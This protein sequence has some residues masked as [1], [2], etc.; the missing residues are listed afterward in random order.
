MVKTQQPRPT[1]PSTPPPPYREWI[2]ALIAA[3]VGAPFVFVFAQAMA[4]AELRRFENPMRAFIGDRLFERLAAGEKTEQHYYGANLSAPDFTLK[5]K[6]G[7][8]WRLSDAR[9]KVVVMNFWTITCQPCVKEMPSLV[10]LAKAAR[11]RGDVEVIAV[12]TDNNWEEVKAIFPPASELRVL[13][14]PKREVVRDKYGT[15]LFPETWI[16]DREGVIRLRVDGQREWSEP[17]ALE[18]IDRFR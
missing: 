13:F 15:R 2:P 5:D 4:D 18:V 9:G 3:V 1:N 16:I 12:T 6:D 17:L 14:D 8:T 11:Q 10:A 7:K